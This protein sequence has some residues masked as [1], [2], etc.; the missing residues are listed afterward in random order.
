MVEIIRLRKNHE[1]EFLEVRE[2]FEQEFSGQPI[3][4]EMYFNPKRYIEQTFAYRE[5]GEIFG[6]LTKSDLPH[7][8]LSLDFLAVR[9]DRRGMGIGRALVTDL[10]KFAKN[11]G[12]SQIRLKPRTT[13]KTVMFYKNQ[14]YDF[15]AS[16]DNKWMFKLLN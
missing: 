13:Y 8:V 2:I 15:D 6:G 3:V 4:R 16:T 7:N 12:I 10:E 9:E 11:R 14:G 1:K 5:S